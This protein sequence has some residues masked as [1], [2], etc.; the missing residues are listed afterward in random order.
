M[1]IAPKLTGYRIYLSFAFLF[2]LLMFQLQ[3]ISFQM[4]EVFKKLSWQK[5]CPLYKP[6][7]D[8]PP[9]R[10]VLFSQKIL[11]WYHLVIFRPFKA[12][13]Y[14]FLNLWEGVGLFGPCSP[15]PQFV[16]RTNFLPTLF[17]EYLPKHFNLLG[18]SQP[19]KSSDVQNGKVR[20]ETKTGVG[21]SHGVQLLQGWL[22]YLLQIIC[23]EGL[24]N[25]YKAG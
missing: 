5:N 8:T 15:P 3:I 7:S 2:H 10:F 25:Y 22:E 21:G 4:R 1:K 16:Q 19:K 14:P 13:F 12:A 6:S 9:S 20:C 18:P 23:H 24:A 11:C 17:F